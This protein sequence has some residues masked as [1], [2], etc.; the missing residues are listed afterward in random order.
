[1]SLL[2][3]DFMRRAR[4]L[5]ED[6]R[7]FLLDTMARMNKKAWEAHSKY[8]HPASWQEKKEA[9]SV[10]AFEIQKGII[11]A[12]LLLDSPVERTAIQVEKRIQE[13]E[14]I[15]K[16]EG[17]PSLTRAMYMTYKR[18][19]SSMCPELEEITGTEKYNLVLSKDRISS[20]QKEYYQQKMFD[21]LQASDLDREKFIAEVTHPYS[22]HKTHNPTSAERQRD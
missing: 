5:T 19:M 7:A 21:Y 15:Q 3:S 13:I 1:M 14:R 9:E 12:Y 17:F 10:F 4:Y 16:K 20:E 22:Q 11:T 8:N 2:E 6:K 18:D